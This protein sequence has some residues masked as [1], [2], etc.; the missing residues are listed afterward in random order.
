M[1]NCPTKVVLR[2]LPPKLTEEDFLKIVA[3]FPPHSYFRFCLPDDSLEGLSLPRAYITFNDIESLFDFKERFD[4]YVFVDSEGNESY[5]LAEFAV[6]QT[7]A[8]SKEASASKKADKMDKKQG[9]LYDDP[10]FTAFLKSLE[11][12]GV[13]TKASDTESKKT[14]WE[15]ILEE[16]QARE[17]AAEKTTE[18]TPLVAFLHQ[19]ELEARRKEE[20]SMRHGKPYKPHSASGSRKISRIDKTPR[21]PQAVA[22]RGKDSKRGSVPSYPNREFSHHGKMEEDTNTSSGTAM[23]KTH[24]ENAGGKLQPAATL[25]VDEFPT[26]QGTQPSAAKQPMGSWS[27]RASMWGSISGGPVKDRQKNEHSS[28]T[29]GGGPSKSTSSSPYSSKPST[30][31]TLD[32]STNEL[33]FEREVK[34][35]V[36][37]LTA[38]KEPK[39]QQQMHHHHQT[40]RAFS[41]STQ[42]SSAQS[43][44]HVASDYGAPQ[45][46]R[47]TSGY[48][49]RRGSYYGSRALPGFVSA[50]RR[51]GKPS[52]R[53]RRDSDSSLQGYTGDPVESSRDT[54][55]ERGSAHLRPQSNR[56]RRG[57]CPNSS[58]SGHGGY[59]NDNDSTHHRGSHRGGHQHRNNVAAGT[60]E[61]PD[62]SHRSGYSD[63]YSGSSSRYR[64]SWWR[65]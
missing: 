8:S 51:P 31:T 2:R 36:S 47:D 63:F 13:A 21:G 12:S 44:D 56:G 5:A 15:S 3:P 55:V 46:S 39:K 41:E 60:E 48:R 29:S 24:K 43:V 61:Y 19:R 42:S 53:G 27:D 54:S 26:M 45:S 4:N 64:R 28:S 65:S 16:I 14:P 20:E 25:N 11:S 57:G 50:S 1:K 17:S 9:T 59:G 52:N 34:N 23:D 10:E 35:T 62:E 7:L 49:G 37:K 22:R 30:P 33:D 6:C 58:G 18:V 40:N 32:Q 38:A